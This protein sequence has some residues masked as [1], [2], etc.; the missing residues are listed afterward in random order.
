MTA[1]LLGAAMAVQW[2]VGGGRAVSSLP[3]P[4]RWMAENLPLLDGGEP[5]WIWRGP[6][7][8]AVLLTVPLVW[9]VTNHAAS[10]SPRLLTRGGLLVAA[11]AIGIEYNSPGGYGWIFDL[12]ALLAALIG[13]VWCG[14]QALRRGLLPRSVAW[15]LIAALPLTP[16]AGFLTFWYLPPGLAMGTLLAWAI[17]GVTIG[18]RRGRPLDETSA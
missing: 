3:A 1:T 16:L 17:A 2:E 4:A 13:T 6:F 12:A 7:F 14:L 11:A 18:R 15:A 9:A 10:A 5:V 8:V